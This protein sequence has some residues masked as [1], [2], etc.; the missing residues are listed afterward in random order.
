VKLL[1]SF[2]EA[3]HRSFSEVLFYIRLLI[4]LA[5]DKTS[6]TSTLVLRE[7]PDIEQSNNIKF[8]SDDTKVA[9]K[10][11]VLSKIYY[12][13]ENNYDDEK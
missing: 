10:A 5:G 9:L 12:T 3:S 7:L 8:K 4:S 13:D 1:R 11:I 6:K 2:S